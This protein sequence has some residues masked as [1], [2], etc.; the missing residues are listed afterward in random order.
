MHERI[1]SLREQGKEILLVDVSEE[2]RL[3]RVLDSGYGSGRDLA[4]RFTI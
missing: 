1:Q 2:A 4:S 3:M